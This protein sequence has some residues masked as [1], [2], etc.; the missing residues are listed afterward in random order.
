MARRQERRRKRPQT[1]R[2]YP[3]TA[4]LNSLLQQ[5][6]ASQLANLD[7]ERL[8]LITVTSVDV[9]NDL[10]KA[11]VFV[12]SMD[13]EAQDEEILGILAEYRIEMQ[14]AIANEA[15]LRK[16]PQVVFFFDPAVRAGARIEEI[17]G[18]IYPE[19]QKP[20]SDSSGPLAD[21]Y[22]QNLENQE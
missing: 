7:D 17:L 10:N 14:S 18:D 12:S 2:Q 13:D 16:T 4:R 9:D 6:I 20:D 15:R 19:G 21:T 22:D 5:I 3:R 11:K 8:D 1:K